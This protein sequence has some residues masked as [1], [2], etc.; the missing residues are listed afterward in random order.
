MS[1]RS[2]TA[3]LLLGSSAPLFASI[4]VGRGEIALTATARVEADNNIYSNN[5]EVSDTIFVVEPGARFVR[6]AGLANFDLEA[7]LTV[8]RFADFSDEDSED[9]FARLNFTY[10]SSE[11][12]LFTAYAS[13][14]RNTRAD[15]LVQAR[16]ESDDIEL[17]ANLKHQF[18]QKLGYRIAGNYLN[19]DQLTTGYSDTTESSISLDGLYEYSPKL[20]VVGGVILGSVSTSGTPANRISPDGSDFGVSAGVEGDISPKV[21]GR[22]RAGYNWRDFDHPVTGANDEGYLLDTNLTWSATEA[23]S[24]RAY[25]TRKFSVTA[26]DQSLVRQTIGIALESRFRTKGSIIGSIAQ[27]NNEFSGSGVFAGRKDDGIVVTGR[28]GWDFTDHATAQIGV[29]VREMD[30]PLPIAD[31]SRA[32]WSLGAKYSF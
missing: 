30:S 13:Y 4:P 16:V 3:A 21:K 9:P 5:T 27:E 29:N 20:F 11:K 6:N 31:Y 8:Y 1:P 2:L 26:A 22:I 14:L 18:A 12:N 17:T 7:G 15:E 23:L 10:S 25:A 28:L 19:R 24:V 32:T